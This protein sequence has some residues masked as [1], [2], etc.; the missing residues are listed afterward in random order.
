MKWLDSKGGAHADPGGTDTFESYVNI[1]ISEKT[2]VSQ[3]VYLLN[4]SVRPV[5]ARIGVIVDVVT[6]TRERI[7]CTERVL[8][9]VAK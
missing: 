7:A 3:A 2:A 5:L 4:V 9:R 6:P 1:V 8:E